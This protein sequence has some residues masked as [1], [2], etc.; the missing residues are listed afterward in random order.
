[1]I[2]QNIA[3]GHHDFTFTVHRGDYDKALD[4][5]ERIARGWAPVR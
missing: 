3:D 5:L 2:V 1:M 4:I